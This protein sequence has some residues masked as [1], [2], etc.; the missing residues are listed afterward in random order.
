MTAIAAVLGLPGF[1]L[2]NPTGGVV[3]DGAATIS[4]AGSV[5]NV[6]QSTSRAIINWQSFSIGLGQ[7]VN[8]YQPSA[9]SVTLNRVV[10]NEQ[11]VIAGALN[12]NGKVFIVNSNGI[13][14]T[15]D[16]QVNVGGLVASTLDISNSNFMAG[17]YTFSGS[18]AAAVVNKGAIDAADGGYVAL[19]GKTVSNEGT[20]DA[21]LGTIALASGEAITLDFGGDSLLDVTIDK[22]AYN[23]LVANKGLIKAD[24]GQVVMTAKAADAVLSAQVNNS[25]VI[26]ARTLADLTGGSSSSG[27]TV[28]VGKIKLVASG[29]TTKVAGALDASAPNGGKGGTIETSGN[30]VT[31]A[32]SAVVTTASSTG[33]TGTWIIDPD[34][35]TIGPNGDITGTLLGSLL[36]NNNIT[37][38][39]TSGSGSDGNIDVDSAVSWSANTILTLNA[40]SNININAPITATGASAGLV[41]SY[42]GFATTGG[43]TSGTNYNISTANGAEV[44]LSGASASLEINGARYTLLQ[45]MSALNAFAS[46]TATG[47]YALGQDLDASG[48]TYAKPVIGTLTGTFAGLG[49]TISNLTGSGGKSTAVSLIGT[50]G[51]ATARTATVRDI[52]LVNV[53]LTG[54][55]TMGALV[56]LNW[57]SINNAYV[58]GGTVTGA[59]GVGGLAG[60]NFGGT[61][62]NSWTNVTVAGI[63]T[64]GG[65]VGTNSAMNAS[66]GAPGAQGVITNSY[67]LGTVKPVSPSTVTRNI[68]GGLVGINNGGLIQNSYAA[69]TLNFGAPN[70]S[71][72]DGNYIGGLVGEN[73]YNP[74][75]STVG[76]I[77]NSHAAVDV[78]APGSYIGG[79]VGYN[80]GGNIDGSYATGNVSNPYATTTSTFQYV[81]GLVGYNIPMSTST[82]VNGVLV[83]TNHGGTIG[84]SYATGN[85]NAPN[86]SYVGG[87][88]G[89]NIG[90][91]ISGSYTTGNVTGFNGVGGLVGTSSGTISNSRA[92]GDVT[93]RFWTG[94]FIGSN[95]GT[96]TSSS[97]TGAVFGGDRTGGFAGGNAGTIDSSSA[98][99]NV[100]GTTNVG[101][102]VGFNQG[103]QGASGAGAISNSAASGDVSGSSNVGGLVGNNAAASDCCNAGSVTGSSA[104]GSVSGSGD[105]SGGL[106]GLNAGTLANSSYHDVKAEARAAAQLAQTRQA[107]F[108]A[109]NVISNTAE[110]SAAKPPNAAASTAGGR[111]AVAAANSSTDV[112]DNVT[113]QQPSQTPL[114]AARARVPHASATTAGGGTHKVHASSPGA[115]YRA[116]IRSID[117]DGQHFDLGTDGKNSAPSPKAQ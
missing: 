22:G 20:I 102:L 112:E 106:V 84:N 46:V 38:A 111:A 43:A 18:S 14:F 60:F 116:R 27:G 49:H 57:G 79:L 99:G 54:V 6:A 77:L 33:E 74:N 82:R 100:S 76:T 81:G 114:P 97:A 35:F 52:G 10:G 64:V 25:G 66:G 47:L 19:L 107:A 108:S 98:S 8:F 7:T 48:A 30:K 68:F 117:V 113:G 55:G 62:A 109:G 94:G 1:A 36:A 42:G 40:T 45:S 89:A 61:I 4:A 2:A 51:S 110:V 91:A 37:L 26:Q 83:F 11:S 88:V 72:G 12:A 44:T 39:S 63:S 29:G 65:L 23:A 3:V 92:S 86:V 70:T 56:N 15:K 103:G 21:K 9:L 24:G 115:H 71:S 104:T 67:A 28:R 95:G 93:G 101:G 13:L 87:L 41:M 105:N 50:I 78:T 73:V 69:G 90:G 75:S 53:A 58:S 96:I 17:N 85:V 32:D 31:I 5:T 34:G 16:A 80:N 59:S